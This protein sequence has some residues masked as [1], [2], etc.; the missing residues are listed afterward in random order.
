MIKLELCLEYAEHTVK[1]D[2]NNEIITEIPINIKSTW[3]D[4][5]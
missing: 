3:L 4:S 5:L 2:V 1:A